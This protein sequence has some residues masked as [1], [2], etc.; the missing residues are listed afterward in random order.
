MIVEFEELENYRHRVALVDGAFDPIHQGHIEYF[1]AA[2]RLALPLLCNVAC[3]EYV[4]QKHEPFLLEGQRLAILDSLRFITYT[5]LNRSSTEDV[6]R[7]LQPRFYVKGKDWQG[8]LPEGQVAACEENG[9]EIVFL[10]TDLDSSTD[11]LGRYTGE[12]ERARLQ[13][14][15]EVLETQRPIPVAHYDESYFFGEWRAEGNTYALET[16]RR[17]EARNPKLIKEVF[18]PRRVLD[19]GCGPGALMHLLHELG[20]CSDGV[21]FSPMSR[22]L[23]PA[24]VRDRI[25]RGSVTEPPVADN[26]YDLVICREVLEHLTLLQIREAVRHIARITSRYAYVTSRF[27]PHPRGLLDVTDQKEVDPT[28]ITLVHKDFLRLLFLLEGMRPR[29]DLEA[30]LDWLKKGRVLVFEK[31]SRH[32]V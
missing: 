14:L 23:A 16:R 1:R 27:H 12:S 6:L 18:Q 17:I 11:I 3:D 20:V 19:L 5:H 8:R 10:D 29:P 21:D 26:S 4:R 22:E 9:I 7:E 25:I 28:H 24:E 15:E 31:V 13:A 30:R 32:L 2:E